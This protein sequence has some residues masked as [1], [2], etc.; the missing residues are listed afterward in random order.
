MVALIIHMV[1]VFKTKD[2]KIVFSGD[3]APSTN[4]NKFA[5]GAQILVHEV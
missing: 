3:T 1:L 5:Q 4:L 2:K